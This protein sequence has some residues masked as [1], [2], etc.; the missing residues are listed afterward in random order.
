MATDDRLA[1]VAVFVGVAVVVALV[2]GLV[3]SLGSPGPEDTAAAYPNASDMVPDVVEATDGTVGSE[4]VGDERRV[5]L[6]DD[7]HANRFEEDDLRPLLDTLGGRHDVTFTSDNRGDLDAS[8]AAADAYVVIDPAVP[9]SEE[10]VSEVRAFVE[11]GGRL[12]VLAEPTRVGVSGGPF[13]GIVDVRS[14]VGQLGSAFGIRFGTDYLYDDANNEGN[15]KRVL[16]EGAGEI[17]GERAALYTATTVE[18]TDGTT[19]LT[20]AETARLSTRSNARRHTVAVRSG[21]VVAVGDSSFLGGGRAVVADNERLVRT[22]AAFAVGGQRVRDVADYPHFLSDEPQIGYTSG[23][24]LNASKAVAR[25]VHAAGRSPTVSA[26]TR[27][28]APRRTDVLVTTFDDL[29]R[30]NAPET[31]IEVTTTS[32]TVPGYDGPRDGV[33]VV[34]RPEGPIDLVIAAASPERA[35]AVVRSMGDGSIRDD[36]LSNRTAVTVVPPEDE[37]EEDGTEPPTGGE[38]A[39]PTGEAGASLAGPVARP[40]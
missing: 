20:T 27:S 3:A 25:D 32:V 8:L 10:Q 12:V 6:I 21:N 19:L 39:P 38:P 4:P 15:Y 11:D 2:V 23:G 26:S 30:S 13:G 33:A 36:V 22:I 31:G 40:A 16:A 24:L 9:H 18:A 37:D 17:D 5:V 35:T 28:L 34:H 14:R 1:R 29:E 7:S